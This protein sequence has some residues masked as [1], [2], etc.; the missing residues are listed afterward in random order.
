MD[1][2]YSGHGVQFSYP[3]TWEISEQ[4]QPGEVS[5]TVSS[6]GTA[7]WNLTL[8]FDEP[9]PESIIEATL[10]AFREEYDELDIYPAT[11]AVCRRPAVARDLEFVCLE[12][13]NSAWVR[14]FRAPEFSALV[15]YQATDAELHEI[16]PV[17]E[18]ITQSLIFD[19]SGQMDDENCAR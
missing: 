3:A 18:G 15:L 19:E 17:M 1:E 8:F 13:L 16:L 14:A 9:D 7:F 4:R 5:I 10:D 6:P 11:A 2:T 12:L